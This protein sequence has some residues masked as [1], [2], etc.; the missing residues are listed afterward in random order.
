MVGLIRKVKSWAFCQA[1]LR[2]FPEERHKRPL[3]TSETPQ[4]GGQR[5]LAGHPEAQRRLV[6]DQHGEIGDHPEEQAQRW[7][8]TATADQHL[9]LLDKS[10]RSRQEEAM[11]AQADHLQR[12]LRAHQEPRDTS[13]RL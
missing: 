13:A 12:L 9:R 7:R 6:G 1:G 11:E 4:T 5:P 10:W 3:R 8:A 2:H